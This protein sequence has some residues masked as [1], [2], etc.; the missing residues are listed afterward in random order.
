MDTCVPT[1]RI[2]S[3]FREFTANSPE[4]KANLP[5]LRLGGSGDHHATVLFEKCLLHF[6]YQI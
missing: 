6:L 4:N 2:Y 1:Y 5:Q 3:D